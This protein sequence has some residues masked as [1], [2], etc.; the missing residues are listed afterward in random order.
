MFYEEGNALNTFVRAQGCTQCVL[1]RITECIHHFCLFTRKIRKDPFKSYID[2]ISMNLEFKHNIYQN[3]LNKIYNKDKL[4]QNVY[5]VHHIIIIII[6]CQFTDLDFFLAY[7]S[8][9][10]YTFQ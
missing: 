2:L 6:I 3:E 9:A 10:T 1:E 8:R 7:F 4:M 5:S